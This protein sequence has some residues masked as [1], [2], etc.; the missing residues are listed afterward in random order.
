MGLL[1]NF[2]HGYC[3]ENNLKINKKYQSSDKKTLD[4]LRI[5]Y[6]TIYKMIIKIINNKEECKT[7]LQ[8]IRV[9]HP[10]KGVNPI[11]GNVAYGRKRMQH[12]K[13]LQ[14]K[15]SQKST[16]NIRL[17]CGCFGKYSKN[18]MEYKTMCLLHSHTNIKNISSIVA[19]TGYNN[20]V[21]TIDYRN[22][23][24][25]SKT[26]SK[27]VGYEISKQGRNGNPVNLAMVGNSKVENKTFA[28]KKAAKAKKGV[29]L[30]KK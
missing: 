20:I 28:V 29:F 12:E 14:N 27:K 3:L 18:K 15:Q 7:P 24:K 1:R 11:E 13:R 25:D 10:S 6:Y 21:G 23:D 22:P 16:V 30:I 19:Y 17:A 5:V 4:I 2:W 26:Y 8:K 9:K